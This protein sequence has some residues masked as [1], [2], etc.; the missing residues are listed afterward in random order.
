MAKRTHA[1][2][3]EQLDIEVWQWRA[4]NAA[5]LVVKP[6]FA[7]I[8]AMIWLGELVSDLAALPGRFRAPEGGRRSID[9]SPPRALSPSDQATVRPFRTP[10]RIH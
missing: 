9:G 4:L 10:A 6:V 5:A 8:A 2:C 7:A 1:E 3:A